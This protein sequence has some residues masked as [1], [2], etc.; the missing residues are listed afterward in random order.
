[1]DWAIVLDWA[2]STH[3]WFDWLFWF[4]R[5]NFKRIKG[6]PMD[7]SILAQS[8]RFCF[9]DLFDSIG[10]IS[11]NLLSLVEIVNLVTQDTQSVYTEKCCQVPHTSVCLRSGT[12]ENLLVVGFFS[13]SLLHHHYIDISIVPY[14]QVKYWWLSKPISFT[15]LIW[16]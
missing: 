9:F 7:I 11:I 4:T 15:H 5:N 16:K 13:S 12:F 6:Y 2:Y 3:F 14:K 1:M 10:Y 8:T